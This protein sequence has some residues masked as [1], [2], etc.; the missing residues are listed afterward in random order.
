MGTYHSMNPIDE[1]LWAVGMLLF[2]RI[3]NGGSDRLW[4][5]L[6]ILV[7][8]G[9]QNK[10]SMLWFGVGT[11]AGLILTPER[12]RL[13]TPWPWASAFIAMALFSPFVL[14]Q[15]RY[16]WPFLEF[17]RNAALHKVGA[18]S[19][20]DLF[21]GQILVMNPVTAPLWLSGLAFCFASPAGRRYRPVAWIFVA[22]F[23]ILALSGSARVHYLASAFPIVLAAGAVVIERMGVSRLRLPRTAATAMIIGGLV[24]LPLSVPL[25]SPAATVAYQKALRLGPPQER[26][27]SGPLP[28]H[29]ALFLH[30]EALLGPVADVYNGL[31]PSDRDRVAIL[32]SSFGETGAINVLGRKLG[33]PR[34]IGMHN[35]YWLWGPGEITGELMIVVHDSE[36]DLGAWFRDCQRKAEIDC[37]YCMPLMDAEAVFV[38][39]DPRRPL[40]DLWPE[41]KYYR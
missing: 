35:Q 6:G 27:E 30:T 23:A 12:R 16:G 37:P 3:L 19:P 25:F 26:E 7:G 5:V 21:L 24:S 15:W 20:L 39:R 32:T 17:S 11:V 33:L 2:A 40:R 38:C 31:P 14:W 34:S 36:S 8:L 4:I 28:L 13:A 1:A 10:V 9:L 29:L 41:M 22:T 18:V